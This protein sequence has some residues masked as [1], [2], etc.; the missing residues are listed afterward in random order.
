LDGK[1]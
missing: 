1:N